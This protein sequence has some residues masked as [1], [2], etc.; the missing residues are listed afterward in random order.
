M[1]EPF[2]ILVITFARAV[3]RTGL[4]S[5]EPQGVS[6]F[7]FDPFCNPISDVNPLFR[8]LPHVWVQSGSGHALPAG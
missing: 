4:S 5:T 2:I 8:V 7:G 1:L 3:N 6:A